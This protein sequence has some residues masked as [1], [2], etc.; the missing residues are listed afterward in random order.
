MFTG[1]IGGQS[2]YFA[3]SRPAVGTPLQQCP[4][5]LST[6]MGG[7]IMVRYRLMAAIWLGLCILAL[8]SCAR[9]P[10]NRQ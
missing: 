10:G 1:C 9:Q 6:M 3:F 4:P 5:A 8:G 2:N 7:M